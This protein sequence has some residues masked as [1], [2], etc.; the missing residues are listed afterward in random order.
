VHLRAEKEKSYFLVGIPVSSDLLIS[1]FPQYKSS[2]F[3]LRHP[4]GKRTRAGNEVARVCVGVHLTYGQRLDT[5]TGT[6]CLAY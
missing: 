6:L 4:V 1:P 3:F 2:L 5:G